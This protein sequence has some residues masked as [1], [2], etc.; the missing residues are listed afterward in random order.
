MMTNIDHVQKSLSP[1]VCFCSPACSPL[2]HGQALGTV[3]HTTMQ[4]WLL[5]LAC[6]DG[7]L[8]SGTVVVDEDGAVEIIQGQG[9]DAR[10]Q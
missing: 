9:D 3:W 7:F 8:A 2:L 4:D 10:E 6:A 5:N 1:G